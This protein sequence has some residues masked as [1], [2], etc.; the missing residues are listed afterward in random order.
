[1]LS[2]FHPTDF[3]ILYRMSELRQP[4][5]Q[6]APLYFRGNSEWESDYRAAP[7]GRFGINWR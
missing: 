7:F 3:Y 4:G 1:M 5:V 2:L 6:R